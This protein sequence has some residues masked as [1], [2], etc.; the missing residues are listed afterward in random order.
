MEDI[1]FPC[2]SF[3]CHHCSQLAELGISQVPLGQ[4]LLD[5]APFGFCFL[6][7]DLMYASKSR[8]GPRRGI[9]P[10]VISRSIWYTSRGI[11]FLGGKVW[12]DQQGSFVA[13]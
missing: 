1:T 9:G 13:Q 4:I 7:L 6:Q 11:S 12:G 3:S 5:D 10:S 2:N 8:F